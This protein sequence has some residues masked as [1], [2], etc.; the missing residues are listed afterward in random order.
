[1]HNI[2]WSSFT[3]VRI[4]FLS[5]AY[6]IYGMAAIYQRCGTEP[7]AKMPTRPGTCHRNQ[8]QRRRKIVARPPVTVFDQKQLMQT[9]SNYFVRQPVSRQ[10]ACGRMEIAEAL[11]QRCVESHEAQVDVQGGGDDY[12]QRHRGGN[13]RRRNQLHA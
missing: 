2:Y 4:P 1:M 6:A 10:P 11:R 12:L 3:E 13:K 7:E 5:N 8:D 9:R